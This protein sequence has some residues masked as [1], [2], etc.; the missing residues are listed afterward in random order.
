MGWMRVLNAMGHECLVWNQGVPP[1]DIFDTVEPDVFIGASYDLD[2]ATVKCIKERPEMKV[3]LKAHNWGPMD[4]IIDINEYPIG[5]ATEKEKNLICD[6][7]RKIGKPDLLLNWYHPSR[8]K[9]TMGGWDE[10]GVPTLGLQPA[11]DIFEY[12]PVPSSPEL[13]CDI[14]FVGGFWGYKG[15]Q[16]KELMSPLLY[17]VGKYNIKIFGNSVWPCP[18]YLGSAQDETVRALFSSAKICPNI[19]A[20]HASKFGFEVNE[21][22][23]KLSACKAF[24]I[25]DHIDSLCEDI[26]VNEELPTAKTRQEFQDLIEFY[27]SNPE[28]RTEKAEQ[29]YNTVMGSHTYFHRVENLCRSLGMH[30]E[31]DKAMDLLKGFKHDNTY[32]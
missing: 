23:F 20:P 28:K 26:F 11:A 6:M 32:R 18:Q 24:C 16:I 10:G 15:R 7:K 30:A 19:S 8:M 12:Y 25:S 5:V 31:G 2:R 1:F 27:L 22:V 9:D 21:R 4:K 17:P 3:V 29:C 14:A 13:E